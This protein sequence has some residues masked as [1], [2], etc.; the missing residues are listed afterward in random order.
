[1]V[2]DT[3]LCIFV[4]MSVL[5]ITV[6]IFIFGDFVSA[7][8]RTRMNCTLLHSSVKVILSCIILMSDP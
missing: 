4:C 6:I 5:I 1:M 2:F 8:S 7:S 3:N